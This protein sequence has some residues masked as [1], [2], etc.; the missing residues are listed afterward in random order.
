MARTKTFDEEEVLN[1]A[2]LFFWH[3]GY[4]GTSP[5]EILD[6]LGL[7]RS[8]LYDT[9]GDKRSLFI[10]ALKRYRNTVTAQ[11]VS[12]LEASK[13]VPDTLKGLFQISRNS[14][15]QGESKRGCFMVNS[16]MELAPHDEEIAAIVKENR[17]ALE[18]AFTGAIKRGQEAGQ[19]SK[20]NPPRALARFIMNNLWGLTAHAKSG[21]DKR[22]FDDIIRI[23]LSVVSADRA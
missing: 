9:Y 2:M 14:C 17:E 10:S 5:Q 22:V 23:T 13:N 7:S 11:I 18:T 16:K 1:K 8:S 19:I 12:T 3:K 15:F 20:D 4:N 6:E 21:A